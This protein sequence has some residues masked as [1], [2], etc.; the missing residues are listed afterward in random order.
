MRIGLRVAGLA[1]A[2]FV[3]ATPLAIAQPVQLT[4]ASEILAALTRGREVRAVFHYKDMVLVNDKGQP[5][6]APNAIGGMSL[7]A[8]EHFAAGSIGNPEGYLAASHS[9]LI[10]HPR[11]G[12]VLNYVKVS[13]YD[14]GRVKVGAQYLVPGT[15][16]VRMDETFTTEIAD[17]K[18]KGAAVFYAVR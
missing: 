6:P 14:G 11:H 8:F 13:I 5:E 1:M 2:A 7:D 16:E 15:H 9:Q 4:T 3:M 12:Y 18:G 10:R 17:G